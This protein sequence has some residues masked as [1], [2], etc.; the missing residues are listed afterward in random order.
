MKNFLFLIALILLGLRIGSALSI[1]TSNTVNGRELPIYSVE[2][3]KKQIALTFDAAWG[4]QDSRKA[5]A[6]ANPAP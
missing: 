2:T 5:E 4:N 6:N 1:S 3:N